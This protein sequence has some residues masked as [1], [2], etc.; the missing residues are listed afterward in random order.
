MES[1]A[2][3]DRRWQIWGGPHMVSQRHSHCKSL[4]KR[5]QGQGGQLEMGQYSRPNGAEFPASHSA[6]S[7][8]SLPLCGHQ[9]ALLNEGA[10][11]DE[12]CDLLIATSC[13]FPF[14]RQ[15][16]HHENQGLQAWQ[17]GAVPQSPPLSARHESCGWS[18][19]ISLTKEHIAQPASGSPRREI[20]PFS[21]E[22]P[23][24]HGGK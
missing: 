20:L 24:V 18:E 7:G 15:V 4:R 6:S 23:Q 19:T 11:P 10:D 14:L 12:C 2:V 3:R 9:I 8:R 21:P 1:A 16:E 5:Q 17:H 22:M 13:D